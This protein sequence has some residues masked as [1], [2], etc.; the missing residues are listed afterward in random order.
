MLDSKGRVIGVS[1]G[2]SGGQ[3]LNYAVPVNY[4]KALL[5]R[6][7]HTKAFERSRDY[8]LKEIE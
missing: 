5:K 6:V 2:S 8:I 4:L 7:R 1:V 3:N